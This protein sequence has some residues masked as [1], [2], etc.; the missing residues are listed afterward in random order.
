M[1]WRVSCLRVSALP[2]T[3]HCHLMQD[4]VAALRCTMSGRCFSLGSGNYAKRYVSKLFS[5]AA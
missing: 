4:A 3:W 2:R 1:P 5:L